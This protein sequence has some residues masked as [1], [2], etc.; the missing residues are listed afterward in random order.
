MSPIRIR[1][2]FHLLRF[3]LVVKHPNC[4]SVTLKSKENKVVVGKKDN[5]G[6]EIQFF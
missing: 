3:H 6:A 5:V 2:S 1:F 4:L